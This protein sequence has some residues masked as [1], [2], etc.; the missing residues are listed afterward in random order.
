MKFLVAIFVHQIAQGL[1]A[2]QSGGVCGG[3]RH[4]REGRRRIDQ[5]VLSAR[6]KVSL[7]F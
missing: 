7:E 6:N 2:F 4:A 5:P 1:L 3:L